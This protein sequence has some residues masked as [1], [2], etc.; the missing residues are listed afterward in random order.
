MP[1]V[2]QECYSPLFVLLF[3]LDRCL[4]NQDKGVAAN[5]SPTNWIPFRVLK[6][7][8]GGMIRGRLQVENAIILEE[9]TAL[10]L[11]IEH[12]PCYL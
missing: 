6:T 5:L 11:Y 10:L 7:I 2:G 4:A 8:R 9:E 12:S 3:V 1:C